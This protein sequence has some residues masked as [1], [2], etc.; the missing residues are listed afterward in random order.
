MALSPVTAAPPQYA[1]Q[2]PRPDLMQAAGSA[3][4]AAVAPEAMVSVEPPVIDKAFH[5]R[6]VEDFEA[7]EDAS[8]TNREKAERDHDY[9]HG[10]QWAADEVKKIERRGQPVLTLNMIRGKVDY[11]LGLERANRTKPRALP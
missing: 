3:A 10:K 11:Y 1:L 2:S 7:A 8:R 5:T 4:L 6:L 9:Y